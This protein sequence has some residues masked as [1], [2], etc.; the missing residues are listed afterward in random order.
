MLCAVAGLY[1]SDWKEAGEQF[2]LTLA[3]EPVPSEVRALCALYYLLPLG[4]FQ[5][6]LEQFEKALEQDPLNV[7]I[8]GAFALVLSF[9]EMHDRALAEA[10]KALE[11]DESHWL[12]YFAISFSNVLRGELAEARN[13]AERSV[14]AVPW[15]FQPIGLL[16]G[17]LARLGNKERADELVLKLRQM[18]PAR[19]RVGL[20]LYHVLCSGNDAAADWYAAM[21]ED[22]DPFAAVWSIMK[23]LRSSP[24]WPALAK[25][26]NLPAE[27]I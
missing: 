23:P 27:A 24:R 21:V 3:S 7:F 11:I 12:P 8:R 9:R 5:E 19:E 14:Q 2:R 17:I 22:R 25:M 20:L 4:R 18:G 1:D 15:H 6:A 26:M 10:Q 16:A 13:A